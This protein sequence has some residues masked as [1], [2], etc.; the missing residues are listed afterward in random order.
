MAVVPRS[1]RLLSEL[2]AS[3]KGEL[4]G[5]VTY[6]LRDDADMDMKYWV[7]SIVS[8]SGNIHSLE[9]FCSMTYPDSPPDI[10][11][12]SKVNLPCIDREGRLVPRNVPLLR[13]WKRQH[14]IA[15][16]LR[17]LQPILP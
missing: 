17:S 3:E 11:L 16:V 2:E 7:G 5:R 10:R 12:T 1:F 9:I 8:Q 14:T 13:D 4:D 6:G 15:D